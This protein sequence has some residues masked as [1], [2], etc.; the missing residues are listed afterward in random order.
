MFQTGV[1]S[2]L[3]TSFGTRHR[4]SSTSPSIDYIDAPDQMIGKTL[5]LTREK[6]FF[7]FPTSR[8]LMA[9]Q[10]RLRYLSRCPLYLYSKSQ[11]NALLGE[12]APHEYEIEDIGRDFF[13]TVSIR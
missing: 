12:F 4:S 2:L 13:V 1:S 3:R 5:S 10:R 11:L 9:L 6:A 7:S 8:G